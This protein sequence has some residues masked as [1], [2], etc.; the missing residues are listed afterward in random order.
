MREALQ[1]PRASRPDLSSLRMLTDADVCVFEITPVRLQQNVTEY[2]G[3]LKNS[4]NYID[5][6]YFID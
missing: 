4:L 1:D 2:E 5:C 6:K 3:N